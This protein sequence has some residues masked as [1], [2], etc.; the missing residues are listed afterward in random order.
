MREYQSKL[1]LKV[2]EAYQ[3]DAGVALSQSLF[4]TLSNV[5][6]G[7]V[8]SRI[9]NNAAQDRK[10]IGSYPAEESLAFHCPTNKI[11]KLDLVIFS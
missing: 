5:N 2:S 11:L 1:L 9:R 10:T 4:D 3:Y 6:G 7:I 8:D